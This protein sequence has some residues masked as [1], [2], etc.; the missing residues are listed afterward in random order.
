MLARC[1]PDMR[2]HADTVAMFSSLFDGSR[3]RYAAASAAKDAR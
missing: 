1:A 2:R 3:A